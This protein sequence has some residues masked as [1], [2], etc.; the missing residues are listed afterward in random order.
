MIFDVVMPGFDGN[1]LCACLRARYR[2]AIVLIAFSGAAPSDA[3]G[4]ESFAH[5]DHYF[6]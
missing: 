1:E 5:A 4:R 6:E 3:R 2:D